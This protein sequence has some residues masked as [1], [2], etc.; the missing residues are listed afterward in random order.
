[1]R[2]L[3]WTGLTFVSSSVIAVVA[4]STGTA[5]S[6]DVGSAPSAT[7]VGEVTYFK[8]V[9]PLLDSKCT[10]CHRA[11]GIA[12]FP[13]T[14]VAEV[15][16][17]AEAIK[18]AVTTRTMPPWPATRGC[19]EYQSDLS[20][21]DEQIRTIAAWVDA[22]APAGRA[23]DY[24]PG[25]PAPS[26]EL[27]RVD[28]TL[29]LPSPYTPVK[30]PDDYRCFVLGWTPATD[31]FLTGF[32]VRP[33]NPAMVHHANLYA[34]PPD[35]AAR[36]EALDAA[37][38]GKGYP[39][40][41]GSNLP[42]PSESIASWGPGGGNASF[43]EGTGIKIAAGARLVLQIHYNTS[44]T[45]PAPDSTSIALRLEDHVATEAA[46]LPFTNPDWVVHSSIRLP[47]RTRGITR[48]FTVD[49]SPGLGIITGGLISPGDTM[50]VYW[51]GMHMH[52]LG[53][54]A[55]LKME[56][57]KQGEEC[58]L[59]IDRWNFHWQRTYQFTAP[60]TFAPGDKL[61]L[62][63]EWDNELDHEVRWG[64]LTENEMCIGYLYVTR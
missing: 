29:T 53:T 7:G 35:N 49:P 58:M 33:G 27:S 3:S 60:K 28:A 16:P 9:R 18:A 22:S 39:C 46:I 13:L 44:S 26:G 15:T 1:M 8:D 25:T 42:G 23:E 43:P 45:P 50:K 57:A 34:V 37:D 36:L 12:P 19:A 48:S 38:P 11:G 47:P 21:T 40:F 63:C 54:G 41:G 5:P 62:E 64:E 24:A 59:S 14:T 6:P 17:H 52:A 55:S 56:H 31:K 51:V 32:T 2:A 4:C 30:S 61:S 20:L 10:Q